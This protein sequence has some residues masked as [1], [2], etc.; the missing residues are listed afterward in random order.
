MGAAGTAGMRGRVA[1]G[2]RVGGGVCGFRLGTLLRRARA[3]GRLSAAA[4]RG[5]LPG[6]ARHSA[7]QR[8]RLLSFIVRPRESR[9]SAEFVSSCVG[10]WRFAGVCGA[11]FAGAILPA[12]RSCRTNRCTGPGPPSWLRGG[13]R[14]PQRPRPVSLA[15]RPRGIRTMVPAASVRVQ[16]Y[17]DNAGRDTMV[18]VWFCKVRDAWPNRALHWTAATFPVSRG[19]T[20]LGG[21]GQ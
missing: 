13:H 6:F 18:R 3:F 14:F 5:R 8:P 12:V 20:P 16:Q 11:G 9:W 4:D 7:A 15:V 17:A 1:V 10:I 21:R 2:P 19:I